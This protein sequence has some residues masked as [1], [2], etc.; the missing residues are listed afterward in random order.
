MVHLRSGMDKLIEATPFI[1]MVNQA[2]LYLYYTRMCTIEFK[3]SQ[4]D[5]EAMRRMNEAMSTLFS[6]SLATSAQL[7]PLFENA[8]DDLRG[9]MRGREKE[10]VLA[11]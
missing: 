1:E 9:A 5:K 10:V 8:R 11:L 6:T 2:G 4:V 7:L 3:D